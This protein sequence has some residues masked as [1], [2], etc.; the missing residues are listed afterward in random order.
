M[1]SFPDD[2]KLDIFQAKLHSSTVQTSERQIPALR[3]LFYDSI[4][5]AAQNGFRAAM[6]TVDQP[7]N[8]SKGA[9]MIV[10]EE[11]E[12]RF[13]GALYKHNQL[14]RL[15]I[16]EFVPTEGGGSENFEFLVVLDPGLTH[17]PHRISAQNK[18]SARAAEQLC[19]SKM[20]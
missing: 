12:K 13:P 14:E 7:V 3:K 15:D 6:I 10:S 5:D 4:N 19:K 8:F 1:E 16:D 18:I 9:R 2:F 11:V 20:N 17:A